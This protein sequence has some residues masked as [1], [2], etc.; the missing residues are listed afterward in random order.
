MDV[1]NFLLLLLIGQTPITL[2]QLHRHHFDLI[3][4]FCHT[5]AIWLIEKVASRNDRAIYKA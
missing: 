5:I 3:E 4:T 2:S 1:V